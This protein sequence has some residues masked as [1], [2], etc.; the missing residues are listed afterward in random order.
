MP[1]VVAAHHPNGVFSIATLGRTIGRQYGIPHCNVTAFTANSDR[2][3]VFG[4]YQ[5]LTLQTDR[6][7]SRVYM[8]DLAADRAFDVTDVVEITEGAVVFSGDL[9]AT[10]GRS[11]QP[12]TDTS[13]PGVVIVLQ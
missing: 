9:I 13:E 7:V 2:I 6:Q 4:E 5:T 1:F 8:Q 12:D 3:G 11:A 10:I